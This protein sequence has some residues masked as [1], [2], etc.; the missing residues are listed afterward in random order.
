MPFSLFLRK[1]WAQRLGKASENSLN[2]GDF[3]GEPTASLE[4]L[5]SQAHDSD[6]APCANSTRKA[7]I[8]SCKRAVRERFVYTFLETQP[9]RLNRSNAKNGLTGALLVLAAVTVP[10]W[11]DYPTTVLSQGP[12]GYWRLNETIQPL[13]ILNIGSVGAKGNGTYFDAIRGVKPGAI[14]GDPSGSAVGFS[15]IKD[16][17]R[18][19]VPFQS[20]WNPTGPLTVEFWAKPAQT[21]SIECPAASV[22]FIEP[23]PPQFP[24]PQRNGWL[25]YQ[26]DST[27]ANGSGWTF[28]EYDNAGPG[29]TNLTAA[30]IDMGLDTNQWYHV[31]GVFDGTNISTYVNGILAA[32]SNFVNTPRPNTNSTIPLTFGARAD[33]AAGYFTY[34][35]LI[36]EAAV[37][38]VA[39]SPARI[40][41]HYQAG[42]NPLPATAYSQVVLAD[43]PAGYWRFNE[44][45]DPPAVNLGTFGSAGTGSYVYNAAPGVAGPKPPPYPGFESGNKAVAFDGVGGGYVSVPGLNLN[46]NT[47]TIT[48][49]IYAVGSQPAEGG[50]ILNRSGSANAAGITIDVG[51]GLALS[52]N[53]NNDTA[54]F[55]WAS[56]ISAVDSDWTYVAL[57][58]RPTQAELYAVSG[59]NYTSWMGATNQVNHQPSSFAGPTLFGADYGPAGNL[60]LNGTIDEVAIF[61]RSLSEGELYTAYSSA[62]GGIAPQ[63]FTDVAAPANAPYIGDTLSLMV[64]AGGTPS[65]RYQWRK[66]TMAISGATSNVFTITGLRSTDA[67]SYDVVITNAYGKVTSSAAVIT[68]QTPTAP[69]ISQGPN[70]RTLYQG[71]LLDLT[72]VASGGDLQYQWQKDGTNLPGATGSAYVVSGVSGADTGAYQ[73][74]VTNFSG[75]ASAGP[76]T[77]KVIVPATNTYE[78]TI[79]NDGPEAW[80]RL[81]EPAGSTSMFDAMGR[82]DGTYVGPGVTLGAAGVVANGAPDTAASFDG[83]NGFGDVPY[84]SD[85]NSEE[86]TIEAWALLTDNTIARAPVS[87]YDTSSHKGILFM[88]I[89]RGVNLGGIPDGT[90][91]I[92]VGVNNTEDL[93]YEPNGNLSIGKWAYLAAT[94]SAVGG[95]LNGYLNGQRIDGGPDFVRNSKFDFLIGST[96]WPTV[97]GT[98]ARW[99]GT[100]DEV[101]VYKHALTAQQIQNHYIQALYGNNTKPVFLVQPQPVTR[102]QGDGA[103]FSPHVEGSI[104]ITYQWLKNGVAIPNAT[105]T[106]LSFG[107]TA[108]SD[109]GN[110][111]LVA[112]NPAGTNGS[113]VVALTVLPPVTFANATNG[114]VLHLKFDGNYTDASGRGNNGTP[115][116]SPKFVQGLMGQALHYST[117]TDTGATGGNVTNANYVTLGR[118]SDLQFGATNSF[119]VAF[120]VRLP[121][122]S[123]DGDLP[124]FGSATNSANNPGFTFCQSYKLGGWQWDLEDFNTNNADVNGLNNSI[125]DGAWHHFAATFDRTAATAVT[126]LEGVQVDSRSITN[127]GVFDNGNTISIGQD[128]TGLYREPGSADLDDLAVWHRV[129]TPIEV[130]EI[131]YSGYHF[132]AALDAYGPVSL[133]VTT[134]GTNA[135]VIWQAGTLQQANTPSSQSSQWSP[136]QGAS[137]PTYSVTP[138]TGAKFYRVHL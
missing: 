95:G 106:A 101:A 35:G 72:V 123:T 133:A 59:T 5:D 45:Q 128:P 98:I 127:V 2:K 44:P 126:Y 136:V 55:N 115:V 92:G 3:A 15:G 124:F 88:A 79:V 53:W 130:Y 21:N 76:V 13:P 9:M 28:R 56:G 84:S 96:N 73:V 22:E 48:G 97:F 125:N 77:I 110:Y 10:A 25:F 91:D 11:A 107:K 19:R 32:S 39:L 42:T 82:H 16:G 105:N 67:G 61:N 30:S 49:W 117:S 6:C 86:F 40:L 102:S 116:G 93:R 129:L 120:W 38:D 78:A 7:K 70:G 81:D 37:Y 4:R 83:T 134:S 24:P 99:K 74:S 43:A 118:P 50:V 34:S 109:A 18:V 63:I 137:P 31:V 135:V 100:I 26:S 90:W 131:F 87:T 62:V 64:D 54:T 57:V 69:V 20:Q 58:I 29:L 47:V 104:P 68:T 51:G 80:W 138:G 17:N 122:L 89:P 27:L 41:A 33:G 14:A 111:Q 94:Y 112:T 46:T 121:Y 114:L 1:L 60:F 23:A 8:C 52:Y 71:G 119:S 66:N 36:D 12:A 113:T 65:L 132:G 75:P 85:L 108:F 103:S